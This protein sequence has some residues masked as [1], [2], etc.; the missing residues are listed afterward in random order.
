MLLFTLQSVFVFNGILTLITASLIYGFFPG[1]I[2]TSGRLWIVACLLSGGA[3]L[4][5]GFRSDLPSMFMM[6]SSADIE[7]R[8]TGFRTELPEYL[9]YSVANGFQ[10]LAYLFSALSLQSLLGRSVSKRWI[11]GTFLAACT[12]VS[13]VLFQ[14]QVPLLSGVTVVVAITTLL[15]STN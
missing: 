15:P 13:P 10:W 2:D 11:F 7:I 9:A 12:A 3:I 8:L 5:T 1:R 14:R 6:N 4:L